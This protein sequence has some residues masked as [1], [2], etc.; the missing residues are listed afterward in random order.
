MKQTKCKLCGLPFVCDNGMWF[1]TCTCAKDRP[2]E[3]AAA[4]G[5]AMPSESS[6][7]PNGFGLCMTHPVCEY[8]RGVVAELQG[9]IHRKPNQANKML[10]NQV[11]DLAC[12]AISLEGLAGEMLATV[13]L[14]VER[15]YLV[16][17]NDEGKLN[18]TKIT[19][20]WEKQLKELQEK[21]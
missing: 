7:E 12:R 14:N 1:T 10:A 17:T 16:A 15:G 11:S 4:Q 21:N 13:K 2:V 9:Q 6:C 19:A 18:L 5:E 20:S 8:M 3:L